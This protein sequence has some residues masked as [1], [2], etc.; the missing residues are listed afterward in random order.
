MKCEKKE[1]GILEAIGYSIY[2]SLVVLQV[3]ILQ[4][5]KLWQDT[6]KNMNANVAESALASSR[7]H[8]PDEAWEVCMLPVTMNG[9]DRDGVS[10]TAASPHVA[11]ITQKEGAT[12]KEKLLGLRE[13][14]GRKSAA[15][16]WWPTCWGG[17]QRRICMAQ[18]DIWGHI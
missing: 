11:F 3:L 17:G 14:R 4:I 6:E 5:V 15:A 8:R 10:G 7:L 9:E 13:G 1:E 16:G 12:A 2:F 18:C